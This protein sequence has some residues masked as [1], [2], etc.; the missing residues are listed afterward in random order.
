MTME[1][2][3]VSYEHLLW[4]IHNIFVKGFSKRSITLCTTSLVVS[5]TTRNGGKAEI[6]Q[7]R[8]L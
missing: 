8:Y 5:L 6:S 1:F 7:R 2:Q 4:Y 3:N